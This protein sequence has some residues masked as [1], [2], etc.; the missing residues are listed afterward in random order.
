MN[1]SL[2]SD[3][4]QHC[5]TSVTSCSTL[6]HCLKYNLLWTKQSNSALLSAHSRQLRLTEMSFSALSV[7]F[8]KIIWD[9]PWTTFK[10]SLAAPWRLKALVDSCD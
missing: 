6:G 5:N 3:A 4:L 9:V 8:R 1:S 7:V 10:F 2:N